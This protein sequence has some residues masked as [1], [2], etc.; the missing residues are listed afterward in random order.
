MRKPPR[1]DPADPIALKAWLLEVRAASAALQDLT[2]DAT[3]PKPH[4]RYSRAHLRHQ[5]RRHFQLLNALLAA[6]DPSP[7]AAADHPNG[8]PVTYAS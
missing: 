3:A 1:I 2:I 8:A 7:P 4:R 5:T 6:L